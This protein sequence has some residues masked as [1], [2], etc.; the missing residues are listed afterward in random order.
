MATQLLDRPSTAA[1]EVVVRVVPETAG[2][3]GG[4]GGSTPPRRRRGGGGGLRTLG[5]IAAL[6]GIAVAVVLLAKAIG[7]FDVNLF[8]TTKVDRSAPVVLTQLRDMS[9]YTAATGE[10]SATVD[11]EEDVDWVPSILAGERTIF[12]GVGSV[13]ATVDFGALTENAVVVGED[14]AVTITL[15]EPSLAKPVVDP[16]RSHVANRDRGLVNRVADVF[17]D[18][19][20]SERELYLTTQQRLAKAAKGSELRTRA[21]ANT[22][23]MLEGLLGKLGFERVDVVFSGSGA[24][25]R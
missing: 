11:I 12:I 15:P 25:A 8:G 19:P 4:P 10:F 16:A 20:T 23:E 24:N 18:N 14:G 21:E 2:G 1:Q 13:D 3:A 7:G 17:T 6:A 9:T 22:R 5:I